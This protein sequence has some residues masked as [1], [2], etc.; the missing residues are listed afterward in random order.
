MTAKPSPA[1]A[2]AACIAGAVAICAPLTT[3]FEG[4]KL[5]PYFDPAHIRTV[6]IGETEN[7]VERAYAADECGALLR[8]RLARDYAPRL[9][10]CLPAL[11]DEQRRPVL[12]AL[13]DASYNAG[14]AA[15]CRSPMAVHVR[16]QQWRPACAALPGWYVTA[17]DRLT[18]KRILL[19]GLV[20]R[21]IAERDLCLKGA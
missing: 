1:L 10:Q 4:L 15:V 13:L 19:A 17:R 11:A 2:I 12:A 5:R 8:Q 14:W 3:R 16:L 21:R 7:V 9:L 18:G 6:C 20:R